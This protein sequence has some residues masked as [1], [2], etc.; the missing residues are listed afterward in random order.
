[1][2]VAEPLPMDASAE[3]DWEQAIGD[4]L[5]ELSGAQDELLSVLNDKRQLLGRS[6]MN[7]LDAI[8]DRERQVLARL[9]H[10][11]DQRA[12]LLQ[13]SADEGEPAQSLRDRAQHLPAA[14]AGPLR[15]R[16][17]SAAAQSRLLKHQCLTNW[18]LAQQSLVHLSQLIE[19][20]AT[21]GRRQPTYSNGATSCATG[22]LVDQE[23]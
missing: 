2:N 1:M 13:R 4:L 21:G 14:Q 12:R 11:H 3:L 20:I 8:A 10:C 9:Q 7:G 23:A 17:D 22:T 19:L 6:D 18:V 15:E 5:T 16:L